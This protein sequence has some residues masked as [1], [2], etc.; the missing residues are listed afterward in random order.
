LTFCILTDILFLQGQLVNQSISTFGV[1]H[2]SRYSLG[3]EVKR[4]AA[5]NDS[6]D[7]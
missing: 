5:G 6:S 4:G 1:N 7:H 3:K 2:N